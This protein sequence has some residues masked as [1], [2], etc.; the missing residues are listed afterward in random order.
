VDYD[1]QIVCGFVV[2]HA[3]A[4][5]APEDRLRLSAFLVG[6]GIRA[7]LVPTTQSPTHRIEGAQLD[8]PQLTVVLSFAR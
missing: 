7:T 8:L 5:F 6:E 4:P 2:T 1:T 3:A